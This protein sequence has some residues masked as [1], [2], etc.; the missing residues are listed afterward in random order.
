[1]DKSWVF[2]YS[3]IKKGAKV[4]LYGAGKI[5]DAFAS[6][7]EATGYCNIV[8]HVDSNYR[9]IHNEKIHT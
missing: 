3:K 7:N 2:P 4:V 8:A 6:Q 5:G 9:D 1:M